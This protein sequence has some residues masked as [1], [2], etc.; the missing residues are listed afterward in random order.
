MYSPYPV[1]R[2]YAIAPVVNM[3]GSRD[4]DSL[5][6]ADSLFAEMTQVRQ[7][8]VLPVNKTLAAMQRMGMD[9]IRSAP[10][11][12]RLANAMGADA[13]VIVAVTAYDPYNPPSIGMTMQLYTARDLGV[14]PEPEARTLSGQALPS[15][16]SDMRA[17]VGPQPVSQVSGIFPATNQTVLKELEDFAKGRSDYESALQERRYL[18][19]IDYYVRFVCH[20]MTRRLLETER[21][22]VG[23]R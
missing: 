3:S 9:S 21:G 5:R 8:N 12:Q 18:V 14:M 4:F 17:D 19:D 7:L 10:D 13:I 11:A 20:A 15:E 6:V 1:V 22:R 2:T 23:S 16:G